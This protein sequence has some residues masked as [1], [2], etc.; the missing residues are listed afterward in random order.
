M[1]N[2][3]PCSFDFYLRQCYLPTSPYLFRVWVGDK[4]MFFPFSAPTVKAG[5][6]SG[7]SP[8]QPAHA[9]FFLDTEVNLP[10]PS[11][12]P[13][14]PTRIATVAACPVQQPPLF[15]CH[16]RRQRKFPLTQPREDP[17]TVTLDPPQK[18]FTSEFREW[19]VFLRV[20]G[21]NFLLF[22]NP[23][24]SRRTRIL[25]SRTLG[26]KQFFTSLSSLSLGC[27]FS[28]YITILVR[29]FR[30]GFFTRHIILPF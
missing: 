29:G 16:F 7:P 24:Q 9:R 20:A 2:W 11:N 19:R 21:D 5:P 12:P 26:G 22:H 30:A 1:T 8:S 10:S 3:P 14:L 15:P 25:R 18:L 13:P 17:S 28:P 4:A 27:R 23:S 6:T